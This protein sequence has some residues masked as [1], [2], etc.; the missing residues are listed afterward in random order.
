VS[1]DVAKLLVCVMRHGLLPVG[2]KQK[3]FN[4]NWIHFSR[5]MVKCVNLSDYSRLVPGSH[6]IAMS[7]LWAQV[8][9]QEKSA[10]ESSKRF[11][12]SFHF[13]YSLIMY[14][15]YVATCFIFERKQVGT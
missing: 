10:F 8:T 9:T 6:G 5:Q 13:V 12:F 14:A 2:W 15:S 7:S 1:L 3:F 11:Q 4:V